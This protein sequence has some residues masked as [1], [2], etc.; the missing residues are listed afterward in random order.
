MPAI[1]LIG[2]DDFLLETRAAVLRCAGAD[3]TRADMSSAIVRLAK[4]PFD[5]VILCHSVPEHVCQTLSGI[6]RQSW[7]GTGVLHISDARSW[8]QCDE[9]GVDVCS[10]DPE[11]LIARTI[12]LLGRRPPAS[13]AG[14]PRLKSIR[15]A[16]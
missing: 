9:D 10:S 4:Q 12:E 11:T 15:T 16:G 13:A 1:L 5:V 6:I 14:P 2:E 7:P 3:I 8:E